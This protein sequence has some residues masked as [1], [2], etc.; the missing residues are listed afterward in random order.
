MSTPLTHK[1]FSCYYS[2]KNDP[3]AAF[4]KTFRVK[5]DQIPDKLVPESV[6]NVDI[7]Q[8]TTIT[9]I[10]GGFEVQ[11]S[12]LV[13]QFKSHLAKQKGQPVVMHKCI[14]LSHD[15]GYKTV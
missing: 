5:I 12:G 15:E 6:H 2:L 1:F 9:M 7:V 4:H 8:A 10:D 13:S 11:E 14:I 3:S